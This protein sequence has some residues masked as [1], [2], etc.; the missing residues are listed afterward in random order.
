MVKRKVRKLNSEEVGDLERKRPRLEN[1]KYGRGRPVPPEIDGVIEQ[2]SLSV[3]LSILNG[4]KILLP[5]LR[6]LSIWPISKSRPLPSPFQT[7]P[8]SAA[9]EEPMQMRMRSNR[10][11]DIETKLPKWY[12]DDKFG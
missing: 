10:V 4:E 1:V 2:S 9:G 3:N 11:V 7:F 12:E 5:S 8:M 6:R